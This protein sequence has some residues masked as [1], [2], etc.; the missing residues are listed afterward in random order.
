MNAKGFL[1]HYWPI[2]NEKNR[3]IRFIINGMFKCSLSRYYKQWT[4]VYCEYKIVI[5]LVEQ[6][7]LSADKNILLLEYKKNK[8]DKKI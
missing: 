6:K 5:L 2:K 7:R 8:I 1:N 3:T 4:P